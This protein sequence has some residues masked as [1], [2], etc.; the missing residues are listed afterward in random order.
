MIVLGGIDWRFADPFADVLAGFNLSGLV[1]SPLVR[2]LLT[3][4]GSDR[5]LTEEDMRKVFEG[6][7]GVDQAA[8]SVRDGRVVVMMTGS[9]TDLRLPPAGAGLKTAL[10]SGN[11]ML[12]GH[13]EAVDQANRRIY[14]K[15]PESD[16][17]QLAEGFQ[18][19]SEFWAIV[20]ARMLGPQAA[21]SGLKRFA[22]N[23]SVR[24]G[25][26]GDVVFEF[27]GTP[28]LE[29]LKKWQKQL[30]PTA[31]IEGYTVHLRASADLQEAQ[32]QLAEIRTSPIGEQLGA[33]IEGARY[34]P[35]R[36]TSVPVRTK[37]VI[38]GLDG[39]PREV[40][41]KPKQ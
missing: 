26:Y 16:L 9:V 36:D 1:N 19:G 4:I 30:G 3:Q 18:A 17:A 8:I 40:G 21:F 28:S 35:V 29:T 5:G 34:L 20:S 37:P 7:G 39:G 10:V 27:N 22:V 41:S 33:L 38:L 32:K 6:L 15:S 2:G 11:G 23:L 24:G 31:T 25:L 12:T 13:A 14:Y